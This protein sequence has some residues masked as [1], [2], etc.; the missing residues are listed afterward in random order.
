MYYYCLVP[1]CK[2]EPFSAG[3][4]SADFSL[5]GFQQIFGR[6]VFGRFSAG[7]PK[8]RFPA[9]M[10]K[11]RI[12]DGKFD[13]KKSTFSKVYNMKTIGVMVFISLL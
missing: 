9:V 1:S 8:N 6:Q 5:V 3:R 2:L 7:F 12:I 11:R 4:F 10:C 13:Q